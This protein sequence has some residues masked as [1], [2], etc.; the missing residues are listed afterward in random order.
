M[1]ALLA[2]RAVVD[3]GF[4]PGAPA[5]SEGSAPD[6][7]LDLAVRL[8]V[9]LAPASTVAVSVAPLERAEPA[10]RRALALGAA[11]AVALWHDALVDGDVPVTA[12]VLTA[13]ARSQSV[14]LLVC[15]GRSEDV[16]TGALPGY[17]AELLGWALVEDATAAE[18]AGSELSVVRQ[19]GGVRETVAAPLPLVLA[20]AHD[21]PAAY[22][23]VAA[24]LRAA[25]A[26]LGTLSLD[27]VGIGERSALAPRCRL[28][29]LTLPKPI[30]VVPMRAASPS[31]E[32]RAAMALSSLMAARVGPLPVPEGIEAAIRTLE[33]AR[34][35]EKG[36]PDKL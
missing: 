23:T 6:P 27:D 4:P 14:D 20:A 26:S 7:S 22:P 30:G 35:I 17:A 13:V 32:I 16:G 31:P 19:R 18:L 9:H 25:R 2:V 12:T 10:L 1:K 29:R 21:A 34:V 28:E 24:R 36:E 5:P 8:A 11:E 33:Q 3:S 15:G